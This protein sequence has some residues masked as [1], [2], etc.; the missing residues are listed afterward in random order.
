MCSLNGVINIYK[1]KGF[2]SHDVVNVVRKTLNRVKTG[3]TGTL[4]P[5]ACGVLPICIGKGTKLSDYIMADIKGYKAEV[6]LGITTN[7]LDVTGDI[8]TQKN[9]NVTKDKI[10]EVINSFV[11]D[12]YQMPPMFSAIKINGQKLYD[13]ARKGKEV[14]RKKRLIKIISIDILSINNNKILIDVVCSKGTYIRSLC[15]DIGEKLKC[16]ACMGELTRVR[17]G[18]F[19]IKDSIKLSDFKQLV[20]DDKL[21]EILIPME[22]ILKEYEKVVMHESINKFLDNGNKV[23]C[24]FIINN[25]NILVGQKVLVFDFSDKLIGIYEVIEEDVLYLKPTTILK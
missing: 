2:T 15:D 16:G 23:K 17:S 18:E 1:E 24:E 10:I 4:D 19:Y 11:G 25:V 14:E 9:V 12:Y 3:H 13:L 7:T 20:A 21:S 6:V 22:K 5:D 8:I